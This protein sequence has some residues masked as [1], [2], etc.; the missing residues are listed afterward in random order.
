MY[1]TDIPIA[2]YIH[3]PWC[4]HKCPYCDFNSH[5][6][7][8]GFSEDD[9]LDAVFTD[10]QNDLSLLSGRQLGSIFIGGGTPSLLSPASIGILLDRVA[11]KC[12]LATGIEITMEANPGTV[13]ENHKWQDFISAGVNRISLGVQSFQPQSLASLQRI[14]SG[15]AARTAVEAIIA[16][17]IPTFN[18]DLMY[19]LPG[20]TPKMAVRDLQILLA[21]PV[22][23]ISWYQLTIEP[24]TAFYS[25]RP[26]LPPD[27]DL[28]HIEEDGLQLLQ[29]AGMQRYEVSAFA[30]LGHKCWH[31][32][33][34]WEF[35]DYLGIGPGA[36]GKVTLNSP[37]RLSRCWKVRQPKD[38]QARM[39]SSCDFVAGKAEISGVEAVYELLLNALR[40][41]DGVPMQ[42]VCQRSGLEP[43]FFSTWYKRNI[44]FGLLVE[45]NNLAT[46]AT[47]LNYL[48]DLLLDFNSLYMSNR[49]NS[50]P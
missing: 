44:D 34:Y 12:G 2:L 24:N 26:Q 41:V 42:L 46:T 5:A 39:A 10:L 4:E 17:G 21:M 11:Q 14:H 33:N 28:A 7:Q 6:L 1:A 36:H 30:R 13:K 40:L 29:Q 22:P 20:Q 15:A 19:G 43:E 25:D 35:G 47:G 27:K 8:G 49:E 3:F 32:C 18:V 45:G 50:P 38:Y 16:T 37:K 48:N 9:Y 31:N 23:H